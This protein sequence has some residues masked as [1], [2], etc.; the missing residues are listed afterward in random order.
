M[1]PGGC[2]SGHGENNTMGA[3]HA[4][5]ACPDVFGFPSASPKGRLRESNA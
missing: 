2:I 4:L 5:G 3:A 1:Y